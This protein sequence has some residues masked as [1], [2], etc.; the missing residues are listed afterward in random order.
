MPT[1]YNNIET[2]FNTTGSLVARKHI[3]INIKTELK[4]P[5]III[6]RGLG[7]HNYF[8]Y[9]M[10]LVDNCPFA[11]SHST[12]FGIMGAGGLITLIGYLGLLGYS[13]YCFVKTL[14]IN[15][16]VSIALLTGLIAFIM[17]HYTECVNFLIV[18][19]TFPIILYYHILYKQTFNNKALY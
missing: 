7:S 6:G 8:L 5:W 2:F 15:K 10:N 16:T 9:Q 4:G 13:I 19:F 18:T 14:K 3:W 1:M 12:H 11:P 17:F